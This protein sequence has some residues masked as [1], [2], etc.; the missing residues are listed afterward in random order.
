MSNVIFFIEI[1]LEACGFMCI[2]GFIAYKRHMYGALRWEDGFYALAMGLIALFSK[3]IPVIRNKVDIW[4]SD[5]T[6]KYER[7]LDIREVLEVVKKLENH[8]YETPTLANYNV[9]IVGESV[10]HVDIKAV[11]VVDK[12]AQIPN[13]TIKEISYNTIQNFFMETRNI[14]VEVYILV[15]TPNR[16]YFEIPLSDRGRKNIEKKIASLPKDENKFDKSDLMEE[17]ISLFDDERKM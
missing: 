8:P 2:I 6:I 4:W 7:N 12:Y 5:N 1:F 10:M 15:A 17:E 11:G 16:L 9:D 3:L 14:Q 13:E